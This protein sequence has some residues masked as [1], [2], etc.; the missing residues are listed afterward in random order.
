LRI[1]V[2]GVNTMGDQQVRVEGFDGAV[3]GKRA[4]L[5]GGPQ[6]WL[7]RLALLESEA[8]YKGRTVL[9]CSMP[10]RGGSPPLGLM[11]RRWDAIFCPRE[12]FDYQMLLTYVANAPKPV[13]VCWW[14]APGTSEIPR[15]IW[16]KWTGGVTLLGFNE[17]AGDLWGVEWDVIFFPLEA[18]SGFV[19]KVLGRRGTGQRQLMSG[20]AEHLDDIRSNGAALCW[21]G[22]LLWYD[23]SEG[24]EAL[25]KLGARDAVQMLEEVRGLLQGGGSSSGGFT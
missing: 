24:S 12:N 5:F 9:V 8:L 23:P 16:S 25:P 21:A 6:Q 10:P 17:S 11:R 4:C 1:Y 14:S 13:R 15:A 3:A 20:I 18:T 22:G 2:K 7:G 19:E